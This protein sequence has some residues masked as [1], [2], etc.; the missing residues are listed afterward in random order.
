MAFEYCKLWGILKERDTYRE[1][2]RIAPSM[3]SAT[4]A[5]LGKNEI[6]SMDVLGRIC[7]E[8]QCDVG[9]SVSYVSE[10]KDGVNVMSI[11]AKEKIQTCGFMIY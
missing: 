11:R 6:V 2:L 7:E 8:L 4:L 5:K 10:E 9:D 1:D 3:S